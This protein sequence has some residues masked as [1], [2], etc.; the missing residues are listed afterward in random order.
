[1]FTPSTARRTGSEV[2]EAYS[3]F[4]TVRCCTTRWDTIATLEVRSATDEGKLIDLSGSASYVLPAAATPRPLITY[5]R[6]RAGMA[7]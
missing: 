6:P 1:M 3:T 7:F 5:R 4:V 2:T